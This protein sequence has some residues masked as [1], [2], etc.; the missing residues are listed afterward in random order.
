MKAHLTETSETKELRSLFDSDQEHE[1]NISNSSSDSQRTHYT[2]PS[3]PQAN[4]VEIAHK[5]KSEVL[6]SKIYFSHIGEERKEKWARAHK[7]EEELD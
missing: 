5:R 7:Q 4:C 3:L 2:L 1:E 6:S